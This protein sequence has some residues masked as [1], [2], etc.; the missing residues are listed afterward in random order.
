[1]VWS[2]YSME[3]KK[4][5]EGMVHTGFEPATI[6]LLGTGWRKY[7]RQ[8]YDYKHDALDLWA[9]APTSGRFCAQVFYMAEF[10]RKSFFISNKE[11]VIQ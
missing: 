3:K 7:R 10:S 5:T 4:N 11:S 2:R 9:N 8:I 1:M 6:A